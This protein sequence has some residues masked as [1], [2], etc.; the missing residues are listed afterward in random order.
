MK[1]QTVC[2]QI[3]DVKFWLI[4]S[5]TWNHLNVCKKKKKKKKSSGSF[6]NDIYKIEYLARKAV[7]VVEF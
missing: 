5:N 6:K 3:T 1:L 7:R 4:Y 2:K